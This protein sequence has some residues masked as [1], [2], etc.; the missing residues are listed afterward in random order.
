MSKNKKSKVKAEE[1]VKPAEVVVEKPAEPAPEKAPEPVVEKPA[2]P[3][4]EK[5][6]EKQPEPAP[7]APEKEDLSAALKQEIALAIREGTPLVLPLAAPPKGPILKFHRLVSGIGVLKYAHYLDSALDLFS[8]DSVFV[9]PFQTVTLRTGVTL[10]IPEGHEGQIRPR[11]SMSK[12]GWLQNIGTVDKH[13]TGELKVVLYN[14][15]PWPRRISAGQKIAQLA[16]SPVSYCHVSEV[17]ENVLGRRVEVPIDQPTK[18][19]PVRGD[20]GFGS[21]GK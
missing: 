7:K 17:Q 11:S 21:T 9:W 1:V 10:E 5:A 15:R 12:A 4:V 13:Y 8:V 3:V 18:A 2:A 16:I 6:P 20:K 14:G 19:D